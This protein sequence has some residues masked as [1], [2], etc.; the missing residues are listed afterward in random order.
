VEEVEAYFAF[1][2]L[3]VYDPDASTIQ[4]VLPAE[5]GTFSML[6]GEE[7]LDGTNV[8]YKGINYKLPFAGKHMIYNSITAIE[9]VKLLKRFN[10]L[11]SDESIKSGIETSVMPA[12]MELIKKNPVIILDGGHNEG[13]AKALADFI[14]K[15]LSD[16]RIVMLSSLM[17]DKDYELCKHRHTFAM[18]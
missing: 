17:E 2:T 3:E 11:I 7:K 9:A 13:C 6:A 14:K 5:T 10:V 18:S 12:R 15:H 1:Y 16:R 4:A 8:E